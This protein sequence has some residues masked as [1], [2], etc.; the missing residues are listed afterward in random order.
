MEHF[1]YASLRAA[2][3]G[4]SIGHALLELSTALT[5]RATAVVAGTELLDGLALGVGEPNVESIVG[6]LFGAD[7]FRGD[8]V[9]Y[10]AEENSL[11]DRVLE[12]RL[13]M[14]IT[15]AAVT[16]EVGRRVGVP[17]H[18]VSMPGHV[19]V[20]TGDPHRF[21]DAFGGA[22]VNFNGLATRLASIFGDD[23]SLAPHDLEVLDPVGAVNRVCNNLLR[24]WNS[25]RSGKIDRLLALRLAIP[26][27]QADRKLVLGIAEARGRFDIAAAVREE[28]NPD[29]PQIPNLWARLN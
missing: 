3:A 12:R 5:G 29:D 28:L 23:A 13:G 10:H 6:S 16:I 7:G 14:P 9:N 22:C 20:G 21:I 11:L 19:V 24:T 1:D 8:V 26:G 2:L 27:S 15:L 4:D 17:L 25:D 18:M